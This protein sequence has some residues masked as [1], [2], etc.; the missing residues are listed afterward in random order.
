[1]TD[2][3]KLR[4]IID[5]EYDLNG[6]E[7]RDMAIQLGHAAQFLAGEGMLS[8]CSDAE[9]DTWTYLVVEP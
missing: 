2:K 6:A 9:V 4:L 8:G 1:M 5:V 3:V 7:P